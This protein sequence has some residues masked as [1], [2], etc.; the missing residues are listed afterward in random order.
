MKWVKRIGPIVIVLL[1]VSVAV[2]WMLPHTAEIPQGLRVE[3]L[4]VGQGDCVLIR[5]GKWAMMIDT[6]TAMERE[7]VRAALH[8]RAIEHLDYLVLTHPHEDHIGNAR[9]IVESYTVSAVLLSNADG[10]GTDQYL[11]EE[12]AARRGTPVR[13]L[14]T[15]EMF[16]LGEAEVEVLYAPTGAKDVNDDSLVLRVT[17][18]ETAFLF[19]GDA[20]KKGEAALLAAVPAEKLKCDLLKAGHHGSENSM[21]E[22]LLSAASPRY[23]PISCGKENEYGFPHNAV[24][25]RLTERGIPVHRTDLYGDLIYDSDGVTVTFINEDGGGK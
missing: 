6:S 16:A 10:E 18:G 12:A 7:H 20:E 21:G 19:T 3:I 2:L 22:G 24:L 25:E 11:I 14:A 4:D 23:A 8:D 15:G 1:L 9:M 17:Y 5:Q 13:R